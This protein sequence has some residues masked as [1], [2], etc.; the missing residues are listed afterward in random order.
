MAF[1]AQYAHPVEHIIANVAP[2]VLP[3]AFRHAH[4]LTFCI[5]LAYSLLET[6]AAHSGYDFFQFPFKAQMH[7]LHHEKFN[8]N[9]GGVWV[10]DYLHGTDQLDWNSSPENKKSS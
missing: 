7:D 4:V 9:F 8:V 5:W 10:L 6:A 2:I 3:L 1:A